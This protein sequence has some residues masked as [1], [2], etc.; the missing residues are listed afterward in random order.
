M[1]ILSYFQGKIFVIDLF[2]CEVNSD[3]LSDILVFGQKATAK[4]S[5]STI[6]KLSY[7]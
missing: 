7:F 3:N 6:Y 5:S 4:P 1:H 2:S